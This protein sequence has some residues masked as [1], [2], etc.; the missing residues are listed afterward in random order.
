MQAINKKLYREL[1]DGRGQV[2]AI[3]MVIA[4]GI[5]TFIMAMSTLHSLTGTRDHYYSEYRFAD[6][7]A[8]LKRAPESLRERIENIAG[9]DKVETRVVAAVK[10]S[11]ENFSDPISGQ[12]ISLP[13][14]GQPSVNRLYL[15][16]GRLPDPDRND[17]V[18]LNE[19]FATAH[20]LKPGGDIAM[21][22]QGRFKSLH[23]VGIAL[24]PEVVYQIA[25]GAVMPD[26]KRFGVMWMSRRA[27]ANAYDMEGAFNDVALTLSHGADAGNVMDDLD[28]LLRD[29]GGLDAF[30]RR[31]QT[32]HRFLQSDLDN[33][34]QMAT[35]FSTIFLSVAA[36]LLNIVVSRMIN[37]Q[38]EQIATLKA[39]GYGNFAIA[40]HYLGFVAV[41]IGAG[42]LVGFAAGA[43]L[44]QGLSELYIKYYRL[45]FLD[46]GVAPGLFVIAALITVAAAAAGTIYSVARAANMPPAQ[47]MQ[48]EQPAVYHQSLVEKLGLKRFFSQLTRMILRHVERRPVKSLLSVIGIACACAIMVL[49]TF[50]R[51]AIEF[52]IDIEFGL[53]QRQDM[54]VTFT[55]PTSRR[56]FYEMQDLE[57]V[58]YAEAFRAVPARL[59]YEHRHYRAGINAFQKK[60]DLYR[61]INTDHVPVDVPQQGVLL[62]DYLANQLRLVPGDIVRMEILEGERP[63][64]ELPVTA[65]I[66]QYIGVAAYMEIDALNTLMNEGDAISGVFLKIDPAYRQSI[67]SALK[68]MPRVGNIDVRAHVIDSYYENIGDLTY[69]FVGFISALAGVITFGVVYNS[70]RIALM[71]RNRELASMR[72]LGFTRGEISY[73]LLGELVLLTL[74]A[75][76]L[77]MILGQQLCR[78]M[79]AHVQLDVVR[80]PLIIEP[81]TY[82]LAAAVVLLAALISG[83]LVRS[84][85]DH[86]DLVA[87]LKTKE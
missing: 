32:S 38:R 74:L 67:Y 40:L 75:L 60:R 80:V 25:P 42:L 63:V 45:P 33:L 2:F 5:A 79:I 50:F 70:A 37:T 10:L 82:A 14:S 78:L 26:Y 34:E 66:S 27:L 12:V 18:V 69:V 49:G 84:R 76:P 44:G 30:E 22:I 62:T 29:Y 48:P 39:F 31:W 28:A 86:L 35:I 72:V 77:G 87:V 58:E 85:L 16:T 20:D 53:S 3:A 36:F 55:E 81:S 65:L 61:T 59:V 21:I 73:I 8:S 13:D 83:L 64:V 7:F 41:I 68:E 52:M 9:V 11:I 71:E 1:W 57:G 15:R 17:E 19:V 51:D 54:T 4:A 6:I 24:S 23:V 46:Y 56:A 47:A 43:W